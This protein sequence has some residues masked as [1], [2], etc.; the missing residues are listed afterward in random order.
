[1]GLAVAPCNVAVTKKGVTAIPVRRRQVQQLSQVWRDLAD[2]PGLQVRNLRA[3][4]WYEWADTNRH[5][6]PT[7]PL[8]NWADQPL[9]NF[10]E[11]FW[12]NT[13]QPSSSTSSTS[14]RA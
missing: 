3:G 11:Y 10:N 14:P 6:F 9:S 4:M 8:N 2:Q 1:M 5:Q 13:Y 7:D 12:T